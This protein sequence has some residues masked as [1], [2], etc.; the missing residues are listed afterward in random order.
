MT[1]REMEAEAAL[2]WRLARNLSALR[3]VQCQTPLLVDREAEIRDDL[4]LIAT[5]SEWPLLQAAA[6]RAL[7]GP[8]KKRAVS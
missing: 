5:Q 3:L 2:Y 8:E 7:H 6:A 4:D 1:G